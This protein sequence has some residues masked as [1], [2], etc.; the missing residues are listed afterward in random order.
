[1]IVR[2][3]RKADFELLLAMPAC[4]RSAHFALH[5]VHAGP[6]TPGPSRRKSR[7]AQLCTDDTPS[8]VVS[9]DNIP[10]DHWIG[11]VV[12]KRHAA[13]SVTRN[14][15]RRQ[16][17]AAALRHAA[18]LQP[19]LWLVRLRSPFD[20]AAFVSASSAPLGAA[21]ASELDRLLMRAG[22]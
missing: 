5:H 13:S 7:S 14:L 9:V 16:I 1:M 12:P 22:Q 19:G 3:L 17:R 2:L 20:K 6:S 18:R 8:E 4:S 21:A 15:L 11:T 10:S